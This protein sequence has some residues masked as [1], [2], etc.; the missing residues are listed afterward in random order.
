MAEVQTD[1]SQLDALAESFVERYR[2]G[3]RPAIA[4]YVRAH[5]ELA[6]EI[7]ELFPALVMME[8][9]DGD[10]RKAA[11][12]P[13]AAVESAAPITQLGDFRIIR[14]VGRGGMGVV[15]EA[16]QVSLG[17]RVA[18]KVLPKQLLADSKHRKRFEREARAAGRLHHTNIVPVYGVGEQDGLHYYVMQ[19]IDG[20]ALDEVLVELKRLREESEAAKRRRTSGQTPQAAAQ[21]DPTLEVSATGIAH[22]LVS[23]Q[24]E[25][26]ILEQETGSENSSEATD[27][28]PQEIQETVVSRRS[29]TLH[30]SGAF[31]LPGQSANDSKLQSRYV[32]WQSVARIGVQAAEA[33]QYAHDQGIIH[34][35]VKPGNL[36]LDTRGCVWVTDFGLAKAADQQNLTHTGDVL[37][38]LRYMAPEQFDGN[39]DAR[40]DVYS[41][42]LTL[43][44]LLSLQPA[45]DAHDR[46]KLIKQVTNGAPSRL[47]TLDPQIPKDLET[48]VHKAIERDPAHRY[49]T[50]HEL[51]AD[52]DRYLGNEPIRAKW[53]S[54]TTRLLRWWKRNPGVGSLGV[55][56]TLLLIAAVVISS[57][58]ALRF[59]KLAG[60]KAQ[61]AGN[62]KSALG[63]A[64]RN[65]TFATSEQQRAEDNLDLALQALDAVYLDAI[66]EEKLLGEPV[67]TQKEPQSPTSE[68]RPILTD[69]ERGL[70]KRGLEFYD[71][72]ARQNAATPRAFVQT[73]K[74][75]YRV[76]LLQAGLDETK[77]AAEAY[78]G[79]IERFERLTKDEPDNAEHFRGLGQAYEGLATVV[80]DWPQAKK[81]FQSGEAAYSKAIELKPDDVSL[82]L[83][84]GDVFKVISDARAVDDYERAIQLEPNHVQGL[85]KCSAYYLL[86]RSSTQP[87]VAFNG[88]D[89][90]SF[91][92]LEK[93]RQRADRALELAPDDAQ[94]HLQ[95]ARVIGAAAAEDTVIMPLGRPFIR[96][97]PDPKPALEHYGRA[98]ELAPN[99]PSGYFARGEFYT[100]IGDYHRALADLNRALEIEPS[101]PSPLR[102]R[103]TAYA[104]LEQFDKALADLATLID[105][106]PHDGRA[107][108]AAGEV[109]MGMGNW[110]SAI[111]ELTQ[112]AEIH[113]LW[114]LVYKRR[115]M[116]YLNLGQYPKA[117]ADLKQA[118]ELF[119]KDTSTLWYSDSLLAK[120][121]REFREGLLQLADKAV[122]RSPLP[123]E[124]YADRGALYARLGDHDKAEADFAKS[125]EIGPTPHAWAM[126][127]NSYV[128]RGMYKEGRE[129]YSKA[130]ELAPGQWL[131]WSN[132]AWAS[133]RLG[134]FPA[135]AAEF[136]K[137]LELYPS[138]H[139]DRAARCVAFVRLEQ[140]EDARGDLATLVA[141]AAKTPHDY[142]DCNV[143][144]VTLHDHRRYRESCQTMLDALAT[145]NDPA[146]ADLIA[147]SC[148]LAPNAVNNYDSPIA[149]AV[150][151]VETEP[152][153]NQ[154]V[155]TLGAILHRAGRYQ[156]A[157]DKLTELDRRLSEPNAK[158]NSS[159]A[160]TWYFLAMTHQAL[161]NAEEAKRWLKQANESTEKA[162]VNTEAPPPWNRRLTLEL[163]RN[164]ANGLIGD[165]AN[166]D[167]DAGAKP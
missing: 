125:A 107:H 121:P 141:S 95:L 80:P 44:E 165:D 139:K 149:L 25:R 33:L 47:R 132:R 116:A 119:P 138:R 101:D 54:P 60:E 3:E 11:N 146:T 161:G 8:Q 52:L 166:G 15:Y 115:A 72:F 158:A 100:A 82:Y 6:H 140:L 63:K 164:E 129:K 10:L 110:E 109:H 2:R 112:A 62:L 17:R 89:G 9:V 162:L 31:A 94:C 76:G 74:A 7:E 13:A 18:L 67:A 113:P 151:A 58:A 42:G 40:S 104:G 59:Q 81:Y 64:E 128:R 136:T 102:T 26:A 66:G 23:G 160:Y 57:V 56:L 91:V 122:E 68:T 45:F 127:G 41:L 155:I 154:F 105:A 137:V 29:E 148:S 93:S 159:R 34:R 88:R 65:L 37:G 150:K 87:G 24:F 22:S 135:A 1:Q 28:A 111:G 147:W 30:G 134:N 143:L 46:R 142:L 77:S 85:L 20:L 78:Q 16:E 144:S 117:L 96:M 98:I 99:S 14:E 86:P 50:A 103:A 51:Y 145:T 131:S 19:F 71:R 27:G 118:L 36:L 38:T 5:P 61:L 53:V 124:A 75:Y 153:S 79:A 35:D 48:I 69:L 49:S 156:E 126:W 123:G 92:H 130:T 163:L 167:S 43:Y 21:M 120:A 84:R 90:V 114:F 133:F 39:A 97:V 12:K 73:A 157:L 152:E 32:Y 70:L 106:R 83:R 55:M 4:E 108:F